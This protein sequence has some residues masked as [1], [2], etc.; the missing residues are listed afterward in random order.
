[1]DPL[2]PLSPTRLFVTH[3]HEALE[4]YDKEVQGAVEKLGL[5][6]STLDMRAFVRKR[7]SPRGGG[8]S[9]T[10]SGAAT[11]GQVDRD[12][13][14]ESESEEYTSEE[15]SDFDEEV[16]DNDG[17]FGFGSGQQLDLNAI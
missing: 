12:S 6:S 16:D 1:M 10:S 8:A 2:L 13:E 7:K 3:R 11:G 17:G 9:G 4:V 14:E 15:Y 5:N